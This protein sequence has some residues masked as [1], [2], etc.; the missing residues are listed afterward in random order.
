MDS[1]RVLA[2]QGVP[3]MGWGVEPSHGH[4]L[5]VPGGAAGLNATSRVRVASRAGPE[6]T[7]G[8]GLEAGRPAEAL[9]SVG[10]QE[11]QPRTQQEKRRART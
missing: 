9:A 7:L 6:V 4:R 10:G 5:P 1:L 8:T 3:E 11:A 2:V